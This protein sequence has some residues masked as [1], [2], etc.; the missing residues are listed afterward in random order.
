[1]FFRAS[2]HNRKVYVWIAL[3]MS[4]RKKNAFDP[5]WDFTDGQCE[6]NYHNKESLPSAR[7][8]TEAMENYPIH[9]LQYKNL[10]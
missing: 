1:M 9:C 8:L 4:P 5:V 6:K 10:P 3:A 7:K 2:N